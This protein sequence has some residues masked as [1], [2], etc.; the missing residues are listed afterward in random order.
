MFGQLF[1][2]LSFK[3]NLI[4]LCSLAAVTDDKPPISPINEY[5]GQ[6]SQVLISLNI[7]IYK[8]VIVLC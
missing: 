7:N 2:V 8:A 4:D 6:R 3:T 1:P 5:N